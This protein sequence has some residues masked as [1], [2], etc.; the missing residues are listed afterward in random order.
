MIDQGRAVANDVAAIPSLHTAFAVLVSVWFFNRV[1][2]RHRWWL[3]PILAVYPIAMLTVLVYS[4][5]H[6]VVDGLIGSVYVVAVLAGLALWDRRRT[7]AV[8]LPA[9]DG[10]PEGS[11]AADGPAE[12]SAATDRPAV[13]SAA[14]DGPAEGSAATDGPAEGSA[15]TDRQAV[16]SAA[17]SAQPAA[18]EGDLAPS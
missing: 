17:A 4:G 1:P 3:Q 8:A 12:G 6:Y 15:A 13:G 7:A 11:A 10:P 2:R 9:A 14:T 16:G 5:E 18:A